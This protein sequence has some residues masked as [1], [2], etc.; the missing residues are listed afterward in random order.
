MLVKHLMQCLFILAVAMGFSLP[1]QAAMVGTAQLQASEL[2]A[3]SV[4]LN[5]KRDWIT[6][7]LVVGGV[8]KIL[9]ARILAVHDER[10]V[11]PAQRSNSLGH[12]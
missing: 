2:A 11:Q 9:A 10:I 8:D 5:A 7:Q 1:G 4:S 3:D 12:M 6:R